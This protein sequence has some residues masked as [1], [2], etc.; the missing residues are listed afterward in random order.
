[1]K[2]KTRNTVVAVLDFA[3]FPA[4]VIAGVLLAFS[5]SA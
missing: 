2:P 1:M 4:G 3:S 5:R